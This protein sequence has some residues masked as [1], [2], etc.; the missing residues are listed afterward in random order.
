M[1]GALE[2]LQEPVEGLETISKVQTQI[3]NL[4]SNQVD[5]FNK[6]TGEFRS[7]YD[8]MSDIS[9]IWDKL[10]SV[11]RASLT[12]IMFGKNRANVGLALIQAFQSGQVEAA[13]EASMNAAGTATA[14]Y[15]KMLKSVQS[16][17]DA[18]K[19]SFE[20]LST[21]IVDSDGLKFLI[22]TGKTLIEIVTFLGKNNIL[23][24]TAL[25]PILTLIQAKDSSNR[26][27]V[28]I[29]GANIK[30]LISSKNITG[31]KSLGS[32][33]AGIFQAN[34]INIGT[35]LIVGA[36]GGIISAVAKAKKAQE[37]LAKAEYEA[38]QKSSEIATTFKEQDKEIASLVGEYAKLSTSSA[39]V[40]ENKEQL[41]SIQEQLI[42]KFGAEAKGIDLVNGK[43]SEQ[44]GLIQELTA[45]QKKDYIANEQGNYETAKAQMGEGLWSIEKTFAS[46][47]R[48]FRKE[49]EE[50]AE[51]NNIAGYNT[52]TGS[53]EG[54]LSE[55]IKGV[56]KIRDLYASQEDHNENN[57]KI[58]TNE[59]NRLV[60]IYNNNRNI[61]GEY[62]KINREL[63]DYL[64]GSSEVSEKTNA[65]INQLAKLYGIM[66][67]KKTSV[68][69]FANA[70]VQANALR[71]KL[72]EVAKS[73]TVVKE[74]LDILA[75]GFETNY[76]SFGET[77]TEFS[78]RFENSLTTSFKDA[79]EIVTNVQNAVEKL[80]DGKGLGNSDAWKLLKADTEGYLKTIQLINGE[81]Y[82]SE[83]ELIAFKDAKINAAKEE[84]QADI[85][86]G[87]TAY[88][89]LGR[90]IE[91]EKQN[92]ALLEQEIALKGLINSPS[93]AKIYSESVSKYR[94][95]IQQAEE[96]MQKLGLDIN[97]DKLLIQELNAGLGESA[98][99]SQEVVRNFNATINALEGQISAVDVQVDALKEKKDV[100][101]E[102][103][104]VLN[105][106]LDILKEQQKVL[107][108]EQKTLQDT[109]SDE[110]KQF[111]DSLK[112]QL[113]DIEE[114]TEA[115]KEQY[116]E[117]IDKVKEENE[118]RDAAYNKE[119]ALIELRKASEQMVKTYSSA[120]GW[121]YG[122]DKSEIE[123]AQRKVDKAE[124]DALVKQLE[125]ERD[126]LLKPLND[127]K[128]DLEKRISEFEK[129][130]KSY[131][132][133]V[134]EIESADGRLLAEQ[135]LGSDW[136]QKIAD[137]DEGLLNDYQR[138]YQSYTDRIKNL[139]DNEI[140][141]IE[142]A[143]KE[144]EKEIGE[145]EKVSKS[146]SNYK[147]Q[148]QNNLNDA[149]KALEDYK[150]SVGNTTG[151]IGGY[152]DL[153][154]NAAE[155]DAW[156]IGNATEDMTRRLESQ[157][158]AL[159]GIF[160]EIEDANDEL[161]RALKDSDW[162]SGDSPMRQ[163]GIS[164]LEKK[165][166]GFSTGGIDDFTGMAMLHGT[167][168]A[169]EIVL[170][171][172][173]ASKLWNLIH[174]LPT[175]LSNSFDSNIAEDRI[176][177]MNQNSISVNIEKIVAD[178]PTQFVNGLDEALNKY[179]TTK[180]TQS[181][182]Y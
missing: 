31:I 24:P 45:E 23:L 158:N 142:D 175:T 143:I 68:T 44:I 127:N 81:Y 169:P 67:D 66:A 95:S 128:K 80:S 39:D 149:K 18:F 171:N 51:V 125:R 16:N 30:E 74:S 58:L 27:A 87:E 61:V 150:E 93:D 103:K 7:T 25:L 181:Y 79:A 77:I 20:E 32:A 162:M 14:E 148:L 1:K 48:A 41:L 72:D 92:L 140:K 174:N 42:D 11:N 147:S 160:R 101:D 177:S 136:R 141:S 76:S 157:K 129:Y 40:A 9:K 83:K 172:S 69:D 123:E 33:I 90:K 86:A 106:Q 54:S 113:D 176:A 134:D 19:G 63:N 94:V 8:I 170:N 2:E 173:D 135:L 91:L 108:D 118:Q 71:E 156:R 5:I 64:Y 126:A 139:K 6:E 75:E 52:A 167:K 122:A 12:E 120:T 73:N 138:Q 137:K 15:D 78:E 163:A 4:T 110:L 49:L 53:I 99:L 28:A 59:Y 34:A 165:L 117:R 155:D 112:E 161:K 82:F 154:A 180:L 145:V 17:I 132:I 115:I 57:L 152:F 105:E 84:I 85:E 3:L 114:Q 153:L 96:A 151:A 88:R 21:T 159:R 131:E 166:Q 37:E 168:S 107:E 121:T 26:S 29:L 102:E 56:E 70:T 55:R 46:E 60:E 182:V 22:N 100:L 178:N 65:D 89:E 62:E 98:I 47:K 109:I 43:Y 179:F 133:V 116:D 119:K 104:N 130:A 35:A 111:E 38:A 10:S 144:K 164:F 13:Y 124:T 36:I 146:Y 50:I 97:R